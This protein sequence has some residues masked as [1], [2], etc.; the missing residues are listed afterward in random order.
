MD[1]KETIKTHYSTATSYQRRRGTMDYITREDTFW[2]WIAAQLDLSKVA[3]LLDIGCGDGE[4]WE[5][6]QKKINPQCKITLADYSPGMLD[7]IRQRINGKNYPNNFEYQQADVCALPFSEQT[8]D[9]V[10]ANMMLYHANSPNQALFEIKRVLHPTGILGLST[11]SLNACEAVY[12]VMHEVESR[13]Q[14]YPYTASF[15]VEVARGVLPKYFNNIE[16]KK[17]IAHMEFTSSK[18]VIEF[19]KTLEA[20]HPIQVDEEF[21]SAC[22]QKIEAIIKREQRFKTDFLGS[23]FLC[24][25]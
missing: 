14:P 5:Y 17:Y 2:Q 25:T 8:F 24:S 12:R 9:I 3:S 4:I 20:F 21:Y 23:L 6:L 19:I 11:N 10:M 22:T 13:I 16:E 15:C 7:S 1:L 18:P